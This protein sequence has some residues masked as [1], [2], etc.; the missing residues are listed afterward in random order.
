MRGQKPAVAGWDRSVLMMQLESLLMAWLLQMQW[1]RVEPDGD[2]RLRKASGQRVWGSIAW[3]QVWPS[4]QGDAPTS[5]LPSTK[6]RK[7]NPSLSQLSLGQDSPASW[8][9]PTSTQQK[10]RQQPLQ[11][12]QGTIC[13]TNSSKG[14]DSLSAR[15]FHL[16]FMKGTW[17]PKHCQAS[18]P[19]P[20]WQICT[21]VK[22]MAFGAIWLQMDQRKSVP[23]DNICNE[24]RNL[25]E[26]GRRE[27]SGGRG[28]DTKQMIIWISFSFRL[29]INTLPDPSPW[30]LQ[31]WWGQAKCDGSLVQIRGK[32][33]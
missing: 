1:K 20:V 22:L 28:K 17:N 32:R 31:W 8:A 11:I 12:K 23:W 24:K 15:S 29:F 7:S 33:D 19:I 14:W 10:K 16:E 3:K 18:Q 5:K 4:I 26:M 6:S 9:G 13:N 2:D 25:C 30:L 21:S 27:H